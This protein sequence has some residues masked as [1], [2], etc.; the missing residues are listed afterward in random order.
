MQAGLACPSCGAPDMGRYCAHCGEK[1]R[2]SHDYS[3]RHYAD[4]LLEVFT[5]F[6]SKI[7]R[8]VWRLVRHPGMLSV[9]YFSGRRIRYV[10][11][12]RLFLLLSIVYFLSNSI[13]PYNAFTTPLAVQLQM[14]N[15]YPGY[16]WS[17]ALQTMQ[18][19][20]YAYP[21]LEHLYDARTAVL[22]KTLVF[23]LIPVFALLFYACL[24]CAR[25]HFAEHVVIATHFWSFALLAIGI[26]IPILLLLLKQLASVM[27]MAV[28]A[29]TADSVP[30]LIL[31]LLFASY[32]F[33]MFRRS[34]ATTYWY[35]GLLALGF[36][37]AFFNILWLYRFLLF[38]VTI[39][40]I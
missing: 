20:G 2:G 26:F 19:H 15:Y 11:P 4:E 17:Q 23:A 3:L 1:Q 5:H 25:R 33:L 29:V 39:R 21:T 12:L 35:S 10:T 37:W 22:S 36:A 27:G 9:D 8:S 32:L 28:G 24:F 18:H 14:N 30:T 6:D 34:Y 38:V 16:A 13:F 7:L 40:M 31:Q